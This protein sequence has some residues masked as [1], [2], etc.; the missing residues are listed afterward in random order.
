MSAQ[1]P[2]C[3]CLQC[4]QHSIGLLMHCQISHES[5]FL[6]MLQQ[7]GCPWSGKLTMKSSTVSS[8]RC[9]IVNCQCESTYSCTSLLQELASCARYQC[10][11]RVLAWSTR[12]ISETEVSKLAI[13]STQCWKPSGEPSPISPTFLLQVFPSDLLQQVWLN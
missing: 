11:H 4:C 12:C 5:R 2:A 6:S 3:A 7:E 1:Q 8:A 10:L 13:D 9:C